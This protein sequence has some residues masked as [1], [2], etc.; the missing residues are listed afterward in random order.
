V[1]PADGHCARQTRSFTPICLTSR[2][3]PTLSVRIGFGAGLT[4]LWPTADIP[5]KY[6]RAKV[7]FTT[8]TGALG[9]ASWTSKVRP[10]KRD[11]RKS[12]WRAKNT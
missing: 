6:F 8:A 10:A 4:T 1:H 5:G 3:T 9:L 2:T 11:S 7:S 12:E